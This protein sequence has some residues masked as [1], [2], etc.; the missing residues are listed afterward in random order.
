V[1]Y[2]NRRLRCDGRPRRWSH[3][4]SHRDELA[5]LRGRLGVTASGQ[6]A[7]AMN[8]VGIDTACHGDLGN[9]RAEL[10]ALRHYLRL[11]HRAV[12]PRVHLLISS[13]PKLDVHDTYRRGARYQDDLADAYKRPGFKP[14]AGGLPGHN[15]PRTS[16]GYMGSAPGTVVR[17]A[18]GQSQPASADPMDAATAP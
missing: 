8:D 18:T 2:R 7:P 11:R 9:R 13:C 1:K 12:P 4:K 14:H 15:L 6:L 10:G 17:A 16:V 3:R 5:C